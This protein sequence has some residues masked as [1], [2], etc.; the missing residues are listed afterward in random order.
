MGGLLTEQ[1]GPVNYRCRLEKQTNV[2]YFT[3][4]AKALFQKGMK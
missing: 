4:S 3:H 1:D 2:Y